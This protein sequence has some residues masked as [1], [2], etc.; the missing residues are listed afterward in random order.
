MTLA[1][2]EIV[3]GVVLSND[4]PLNQ[5]R[6]KAAAPGFFD[7]KTMK[8]DEMF[9]INPFMMFGQQTFSK[10][11]INSK[12][13][14]LHNTKNYFEFWYLPMFEFDTTCPEIGSG[15]AD[16]M[17]A[18]SAGCENAQM[19]YAPKT[20]MNL[21]NGSASVKLDGSGDVNINSGKASIV[22]AEAGTITLSGGEEGGELFSAVQG[23][24][25]VELLNKLSTNL[26]NVSNSLLLSPAVSFVTIAELTKTA[27]ELKEATEG[28]LS[29]V[30]KIS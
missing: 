26:M 20:G 24:K 22:A 30:V 14:V 29:K 18:R 10:M 1:D 9:W 28:L 16:V 12:V 8:V 3:P 6:I 19:Y 21:I 4:D 27:T 2:F 7:D 25:L 23:E 13:W 11:R 5:G 15:E 17:L